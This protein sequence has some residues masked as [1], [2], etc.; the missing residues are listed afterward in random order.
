M[1]GLREIIKT[2]PIFAVAIATHSQPTFGAGRTRPNARHRI[3]I[4][5]KPAFLHRNFDSEY[6]VI[7]V[8][9]SSVARRGQLANSGAK[10]DGA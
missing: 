1:D 2:H 5:I 6:Q 8:R 3:D 7:R 4:D 10:T 9:R